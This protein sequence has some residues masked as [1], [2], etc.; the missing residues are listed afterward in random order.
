[1]TTQ[2]DVAELRATIAALRLILSE[3]S[4][5]EDLTSARRVPALKLTTDALGIIERIQAGKHAIQDAAGALAGRILQVD[6]SGA[7]WG[8]EVWVGGA[9]G[10]RLMTGGLERLAEAIVEAA[11][12][13][14]S[15]RVT[16][17]SRCDHLM[18][19]RGKLLGEIE[20]LNLRLEAVRARLAATRCA[21]GGSQP[22]EVT[23]ADLLPA[24]RPCA[25]VGSG[26]HTACVGHCP[27]SAAMAAARRRG[28]SR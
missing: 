19:D 6:E 1:M 10:L 26:V 7:P 9:A 8:P 5:D 12:E 23:T 13:R 28:A 21:C 17:C 16:A 22:P 3:G 2:S 27:E 14:S 11:V 4:L 20:D 18:A 15:P 24:G 25:C